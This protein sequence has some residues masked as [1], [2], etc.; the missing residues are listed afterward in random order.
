MNLVMTFFFNITYI[1]KINYDMLEIT[2]K[3]SPHRNIAKDHAIS[4]SVLL[5][6]PMLNLI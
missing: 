5:R 1:L 6:H 4:Q 3:L 2:E